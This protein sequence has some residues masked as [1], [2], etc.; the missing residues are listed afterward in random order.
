MAF[1]RVLTTATRQAGKYETP[2]LVVP[3]LSGRLF[4]LR[5]AMD[6]ADLQDSGLAI[7]LGIDASFDGGV[8]WQVLVGG[9]WHGGSPDRQ[10]IFQ[11]PSL[12]WQSGG[13]QPTHVRVRVELPRTVRMGADWDLG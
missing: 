12:S 1:V 11:P 7:P 10:G 4:Q 8:T 5:F 9:T 2:A 3:N 6:L 13:N